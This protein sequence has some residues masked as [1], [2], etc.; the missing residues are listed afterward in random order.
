MEAPGDPFSV[1]AV[2]TDSMRAHN[3]KPDKSDCSAYLSHAQLLS[4][5][6]GFNQ[7]QASNWYHATSLMA[8]TAALATIALD[9]PHAHPKG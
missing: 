9:R 6:V 1:A 7:F 2:F 4:W 8:I 3:I 5:F